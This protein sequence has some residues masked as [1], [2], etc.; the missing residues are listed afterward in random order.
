MKYKYL[1]LPVIPLGI[2]LSS[3]S[4]TGG[5][6]TTVG[7]VPVATCAPTPLPNYVKPNQDVQGTI[8]TLPTKAKI[9]AQL[10]LPDSNNQVYVEY[11]TID[12]AGI[13]G[14]W[15]SKVC[16][17]T[18]NE[19]KTSTIFSKALDPKIGITVTPDVKNPITNHTGEVTISGKDLSGTSWEW[20]SDC[21]NYTGTD[22]Y[23]QDVSW[24][25]LLPVLPKYK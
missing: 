25:Q 22:E 4:F 24:D 10:S 2:L 20:V 5:I 23:D 3:C 7:T 14:N 13:P 18:S 6:F 8:A 19:S 9:C 1:L 15:H 12:N 17:T 11:R 21:F 16:P